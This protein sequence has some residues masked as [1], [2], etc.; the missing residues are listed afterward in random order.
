MEQPGE[1]LQRGGLAGAVRAEEA[2]DL[3]GLDLEGDPV[4]G[5][6]LAVLAA[7]EAL[8][9]SAKP[10][11]PLGDEEGLVQAGDADGGLGHRDEPR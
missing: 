9:G 7:D 6:H 8:D 4:D 1:H 11:L 2:D 3:A 5:A 10:R